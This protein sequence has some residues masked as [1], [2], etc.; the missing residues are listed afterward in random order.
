MFRSYTS[1]KHRVY[2]YLSWVTTS[3]KHQVCPV[4]ATV[5]KTSGLSLVFRATRPQ[6]IGFAY[7]SSKHRVCHLC[8]EDV[9]RL[10]LLHVLKTSGLS[11]VFRSYTSSKHRVC[12]LCLEAT[13]PHN[14]PGVESKETVHVEE[15]DDKMISTPDVFCHC[16]HVSRD[17]LFY[18]KLMRV[19]VC[20]PL[21][22][23]GLLKKA[24]TV[25]KKIFL[26]NIV[27]KRLASNSQILLTK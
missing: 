21:K 10:C 8:L 22:Q 11:P 14:I 20:F 24:G 3:S 18:S 19:L 2:A 9:L 6:N 15:F 27:P 13:R 7:T 16:S 12:R 5:L 26:Q 17:N 25:I 1:S 4:F 23:R